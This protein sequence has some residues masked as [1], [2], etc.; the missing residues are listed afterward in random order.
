MLVRF[1]LASV[2]CPFS[3]LLLVVC[4][5]LP[6]ACVWHACSDRSTCVSATRLVS[7]VEVVAFDVLVCFVLFR[8]ALCAYACGG[9]AVC[10]LFHGFG[11]LRSVFERGLFVCGGVSCFMFHVLC[12]V[13]CAWLRR[14]CVVL[15]SMCVVCVVCVVFVLY[16]LCVVCVLYVFVV[17]WCVVRYHGAPLV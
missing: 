16:V 17:V 3:C 10:G 2:P 9:S 7:A 14:C 4:C 13:L 1:Q 12:F 11:R 6:V 15:F 5:L 8:V